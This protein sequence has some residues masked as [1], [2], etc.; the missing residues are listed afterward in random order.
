MTLR[1]ESIIKN[2]KEIEKIKE[3][4]HE[5]FPKS[6]R[7]P[8]R[9]LLRKAK[10][11]FVDFLAIYDDEV[12]IGFTYIIT[13]GSLI[14][15]LY[16]AIDESVRSKGYGSRVLAQI[17]E[18]YSNNRIILIIEVTDETAAN[19]EQRVTR[20]NFYIRNGYQSSGLIYQDRWGLY[21][22]MLNG[23]TVE[24]EAFYHLLKKFQGSLLFRFFKPQI[25]L[26]TKYK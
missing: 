10:K 21:E 22:V 26:S 2:P 17:K 8:M 13:E 9:F 5:A 23:D 11:D 15:V 4:Y 14:Y 24:S 12:F 19:Y 7:M 16:L 20:K 6:E 25:T 18:M 3:L 1:S